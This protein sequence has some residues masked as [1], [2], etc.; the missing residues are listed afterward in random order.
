MAEN[1]DRR[2]RSRSPNNSRSTA[3]SH[4]PLNAS[5]LVAEITAAVNGNTN[6]K[7]ENLTGRFDSFATEFSGLKTALSG[8]PDQVQHNT[9]RVTL[10]E[11]DLAQL[12][13]QVHRLSATDRA[14]NVFISAAEKFTGSLAG[15]EASWFVQPL[16][17]RAACDVKVLASGRWFVVLRCE[18][19]AI[20]RQLLKQETKQV[21]FEQ[22]RIYIREDLTKA[23]K[24]EQTQLKPIMR[25]LHAKGIKA[26][27]DRSAV[28]WRGV[29]GQRCSIEPWELQTQ[30]VEELQLEA[31]ARHG[32]SG[33]H[34]TEGSAGQRQHTNAPV[35]H[36][37]E[38][39]QNNSPLARTSAQGHAAVPPARTT[40]VQSGQR[41]FSS[42]VQPTANNNATNAAA[43][44]ATDKQPR[45]HTQRTNPPPKHGAVNT[46]SGPG[47]SSTRAASPRQTRAGADTVHAAAK[48]P[49]LHSG[50]SANA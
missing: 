5:E 8:I 31:D 44:P 16:G 7:F 41:L 38:T 27:W 30:S 22:H 10:L 48:N 1:D 45:T 20:K 9:R 50:T 36:G 35:T 32:E 4:E 24:D 29:S 6:T 18:N 34:D 43:R 39:H 37:D 28:V 12:R 14:L 25:Y 13:Y 21:A 40:D 47:S 19:L 17:L 3:P 23:E 11:R 2:S 26:F 33:M 49:F 15:A 42:V 46:R